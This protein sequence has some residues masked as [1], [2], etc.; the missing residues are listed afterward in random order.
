[1][2]LPK[3]LTVPEFCAWARIGKTKA[4]E[5]I[6][7]GQ[8]CALKIGRRTVILASEAEAWLT[9]QPSLAAASQ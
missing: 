9:R 7:T 2:S 5:E 4:Y 3:L 6:S 8:L 1:M